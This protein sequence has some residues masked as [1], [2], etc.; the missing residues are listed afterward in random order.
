MDERGLVDRFVIV[1]IG[2]RFAT[3][4][5]R[6]LM[7]GGRATR[8]AGRGVVV[9]ARGSLSALAA[10]MGSNSEGLAAASVPGRVSGL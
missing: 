9:V 5:S 1:V 6:P 7:C 10:W 3:A 8:D 2:I 4:S